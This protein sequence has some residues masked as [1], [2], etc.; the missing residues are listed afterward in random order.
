MNTI[1]VFTD[2][3]KT[4]RAAANFATELACR[5]DAAILLINSY[6][7]PFALFS[8]ETEGRSM[9]DSAQIAAASDSGLK[10]EARRLR[11]FV[12]KQTST[13]AQPKITTLA[14]IESLTQTLKNL[15][16]ALPISM[17]VMGVHHTS[18]PVL[19]SAIDLE[20]L[21]KQVSYPVL[22]IPKN[23]QSPPI[24]D[25]VFATDLGDEDLSFLRSIEPF[26]RTHKFSIHVCH[27]AKPVFVPDFIQE[28]KI[29]KFERH[30]AML[31]HGNI[32]FT[33]LKGNNIKKTLNEFN[34]SIGA[35]MLGIIYYPHSFVYKALNGSN[36]ARLARNQRLPLLIFPA[37][38]L[39]KN[40]G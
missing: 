15:N 37:N 4:A 14:S 27:I 32:T 9:V 19:F 12:D 1:L 33:V 40:H 20:A 28:D 30:V 3:S 24:A 16:H 25:F 18:L 17:L 36:T 2:F 22:I 5:L 39:V 6:Q 8:A 11:R 21:L 23:C 35:D 38:L 34:A 31:G 26:A 7:L 10:K 29:M 13:A